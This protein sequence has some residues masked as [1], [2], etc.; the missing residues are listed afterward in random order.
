MM[1]RL[2]NLQN[3]TRELKDACAEYN[4]NGASYV[5][6]DKIVQEHDKVIGDAVSC[7]Q[8]IREQ[9]EK[10]VEEIVNSQIGKR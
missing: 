9:G 3:V 2:R 1:D 5:P 7:F 10:E 8:A 4:L 6:I